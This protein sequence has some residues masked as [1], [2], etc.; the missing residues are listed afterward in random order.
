MSIVVSSH[1]RLKNDPARSGMVEDVIERSGRVTVRV[2]FADGT[3][4][5]PLNNWNS[6]LK[7]LRSNRSYPK[8]IVYPPNSLSLFHM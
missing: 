2:A 8:R 4:R 7:L 3:R 6:Y 1:V 5:I